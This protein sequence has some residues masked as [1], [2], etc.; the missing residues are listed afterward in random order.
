MDD[1]CTLSPA[2]LSLWVVHQEQKLVMKI[3]DI[4]LS[5]IGP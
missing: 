3:L 4:V 2:K 1:F 5:A